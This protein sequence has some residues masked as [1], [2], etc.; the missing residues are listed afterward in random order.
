MLVSRSGVTLLDVSPDS[1]PAASWS[2]HE[3]LPCL[4]LLILDEEMAVPVLSVAGDKRYGSAWES[5]M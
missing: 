4:R 5:A 2:C 1:N 3:I